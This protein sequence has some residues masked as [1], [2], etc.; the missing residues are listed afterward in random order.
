MHPLLQLFLAAANGRFP[1]PDGTVVVVAS[2]AADQRAV[3]AFTGH[4]VIAAAVDPGDA[5]ALGADGFGGALHPRVLAWLA[6]ADGTIGVND[7]T[8]VAR[9]QGGSPALAARHD[10]EDH[11][12]V[13][14]ARALRHDVQVLGDERGLV[15]LGL[16]LA[17]RLEMSVEADPGLHG[18]GAGRALIAAALTS[19]PAGEPVFAA[20]SPGNARSL[21]AFLAVGFVP[22]ASELIIVRRAAQ[23]VAVANET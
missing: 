23:E 4:A 17:G 18:T 10:L 11:H 21:R 7:V 19:V 2:P 13:W 6:G 9:G 8:L 3:V 20:V 12:R 1:P 14:H 15:T 22:V 5:R 16:G